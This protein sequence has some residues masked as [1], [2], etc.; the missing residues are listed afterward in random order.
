MKNLTNKKYSVILF[1]TGFFGIIISNLASYNYIC[2]N[3]KY[4]RPIGLIHNS[5]FSD[6]ESAKGIDLGFYIIG[7]RS[8]LIFF[9]LLIACS[10]YIFL[11]K[12]DEE[13]DVYFF[14]IKDK[15]FTKRKIQKSFSS[16][17]KIAITEKQEQVKPENLEAQ[18]EL[19]KIKMLKSN[20]LLYGFILLVLEI[21]LYLIL[22]KYVTEYSMGVIINFSVSIILRFFS[23]YKCNELSEFNKGSSNMWFLFAIML[24][25]VALIIAGMNFSIKKEW[26]NYP[27]LVSK[28]SEQKFSYKPIIKYI[29]YIIIIVLLSVAILYYKNSKSSANQ[30]VDYAPELID[31][32]NINPDVIDT[33]TA[34]SPDTSIVNDINRELLKRK[35]ANLKEDSIVGVKS[36]ED[37]IA[38]VKAIVKLH[39]SLLN[40]K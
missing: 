21:G 11:Y 9:V 17:K 35:N 5:N 22:K 8:V 26:G 29:I 36:K 1:L 38:K 15:Y 2:I 24:P 6:F 7:L 23:A 34:V 25:S 13:I 39:E 3:G 27:Y 19:R 30:V 31:S 12:T 40:F 10:V 16:E 20:G 18:I 14:R 33:N 4:L 37:S 28:T 32:V